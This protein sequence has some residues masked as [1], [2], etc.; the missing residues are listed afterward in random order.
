[1]TLYGE[2]LTKREAAWFFVAIAVFWV[3]GR[4]FRH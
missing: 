1:V 2:E 3:A 4:V